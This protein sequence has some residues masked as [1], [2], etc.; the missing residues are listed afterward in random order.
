MISL[1]LVGETVEEHHNPLL[2][3]SNKYVLYAILIL[4]YV[5]IVFQV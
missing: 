1:E 4:L 3:T 2:D 5:S